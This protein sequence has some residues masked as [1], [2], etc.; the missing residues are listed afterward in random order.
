MATI[1]AFIFLK[2]IM[3]GINIGRS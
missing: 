2:K 1:L 3:L